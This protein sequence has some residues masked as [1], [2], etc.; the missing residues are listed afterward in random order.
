[1]RQLDQIAIA[2]QT[3]TGIDLM[4]RA[5]QAVWDL[6]VENWQE[7]RRIVI[8]CGA[9]NNSGSGVFSSSSSSFF[10]R[11]ISSCFCCLIKSV[12]SK[13]IYSINLDIIFSY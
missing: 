6:L 7:A 5:G 12:I 4:Q 8:V 9:G 3:I 2:E 11:S 1:M 10:R 13:I